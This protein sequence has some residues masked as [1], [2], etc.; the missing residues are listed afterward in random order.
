MAFH[1]QASV[2]GITEAC[3]YN[4]HSVCNNPSCSCDCH[5]LAKAE[6]EAEG[7]IEDGKPEK[8]CPT[9]GVKRPFR[10]TFCRVDG[11]RLT[12]LMCALCGSGGEGG[13]KYCWKCGAP[14]GADQ[15]PSPTGNTSLQVP[16]LSN[17]EDPEV[18]Y[19]HQVLGGIQKELGSQD[20]Q[21]EAQA[22]G[23][24]DG[25]RK[26]VETPM[27]EGGSFK[28]VSSPSPVRV[29]NPAGPSD[30]PGGGDHNPRP[31]GVAARPRP[32]FRLPVKPS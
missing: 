32:G 10:E 20:T 12:S 28:L 17:E 24:E 29:R 16:V 27:G 14:L 23:G 4:D 30:R 31:E 6:V 26:V 2:S 25:N 19:A 3:K 22:E 7:V 18:D 1:D 9:C 15:P 13:D 5:K 21:A 8:A 11:A